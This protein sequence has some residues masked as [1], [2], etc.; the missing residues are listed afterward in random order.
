MTPSMRQR[1]IGNSEYDSIPEK[2]V[3]EK[4]EMTLR[5]IIRGTDE[6][7]TLRDIARAESERRETRRQVVGACYRRIADLDGGES[8]GE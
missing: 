7:S 4:N 1:S 8:D 6:P 5:A 2:L 3:A